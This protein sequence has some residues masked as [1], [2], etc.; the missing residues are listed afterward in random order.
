MPRDPILGRF[1]S[2]KGSYF[3]LEQLKRERSYKQAREIIQSDSLYKIGTQVAANMIIREWRHLRPIPSYRASRDWIQELGWLAQGLLV[4]AEHVRFFV[5]ESRRFESH[6]LRGEYEAAAKNLIEIEARVGI[7][8]WLAERQLMVRQMQEGFDAHKA[9]LAEI[10]AD[11]VDPLVGYLLAMISNRL[12][13]HVIPATFSRDMDQAVG[14]LR[15]LGK[16]HAARLVEFQCDPWHSE[17][18]SQPHPMLHACCD[19][20]LADR[21]SGALRILAY[22]SPEALTESQAK[23]LRAILNDLNAV[24]DDPALRR[25]YAWLIP[26][27]SLGAADACQTNFLRALDDFWC[28]NF[29]SAA[30]ECERLVATEPGAF[31]YYSL[32]AKTLA[33]QPIQSESPIDP[34]SISARLSRALQGIDAAQVEIDVFIIEIEAIALKLGATP[35]GIETW[36]WS[37]RLNNREA[38]IA[39]L[40]YSTLLTGCDPESY[41]SPDR[42]F[43][44][45]LF[46]IDTLEGEH[47]SIWLI[48]TRAAA[49]GG[50]L[51]L[52][53]QILPAFQHLVQA[54]HH[55]FTGA[56]QNALDEL[57]PLI[58]SLSDS[59]TLTNY[60]APEIAQ[61][62]YRALEG[63]CRFLD[64]ARTVVE[65]YVRN[66]NA[67]RYIP[68]VNLLSEKCG[69][70]GTAYYPVLVFLKNGDEQ[71]IYEAVD[72]YFLASNISGPA[73]FLNKVGNPLAAVERVLLRDVLVS[74]VLIRGPF[75]AESPDEQ[76]SL[77]EQILRRLFELCVDDQALVVNELAELEQNRVLA[78]AYRNVE[79]PK[80]SS[81]FGDLNRYLSSLLEGAFERYSAYR[82]FEGKGGQ[83][84]PEEQLLEQVAAGGQ[85]MSERRAESSDVLLSNIVFT[86]IAEY[87][88]GARMGV[89]ATLSTRIRHGSLENQLMRILDAN[90]LLARRDLK[91][92]YTCSKQVL[93]VLDTCPIEKQEKVANAYINF[94]GKIGQIYTDLMSVLRIRAQTSI[95][96]LLGDGAVKELAADDGLLDMRPAFSEEAIAKVRLASPRTPSAL[97]AESHRVFEEHFGNALSAV[98]NHL[99]SNVERQMHVELEVLDGIIVQ[100]LA[101]GWERAQ[102]R[103]WVRNAKDGIP[104]EIQIIQNWFVFTS[105]ADFGLNS[106]HRLFQVAARVVNFASNGRL[107]EIDFERIYDEAIGQDKGVILY[108]VLSILFRNIVQHSNLNP[109]HAQ[110]VECTFGNEHGR[111]TMTV[112]NQM[113]S[114]AGCQS[115]VEAARARLDAP[116][117]PRVLERS[118]GGTGL[119][120]VKALLRQ[121]APEIDVKVEPSVGAEPR[122]FCVKIIF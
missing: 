111:R 6:Y 119:C 110:L 102:L 68:F 85:R 95:L 38:D 80:F 44:R 121:I 14:R 36:Q 92:N 47:P 35:L 73:A 55:C 9:R 60:L 27:A 8:F 103:Q 29:G 64:A 43:V 86:I 12:E 15:T 42:R 30:R 113:Q 37:Q 91:G 53:P 66:K 97:I 13:P 32:L 19:R 3:A 100:E 118:P 41:L 50:E 76:R 105:R 22:A 24:I 81:D 74:P 98:R 106:M 84:A 112:C 48:K 56:F 114:I 72:D 89:N 104:N 61:W 101:D 54:E 46:E 71:D 88:W 65:Y 21:Y 59:S 40:R 4:N 31:H 75:W 26:G 62:E 49:S 115:A 33:C 67:L 69:L 23:Q 58:E 63:S 79:G 11:I 96:S 90:F 57:S 108:E 109:E 39:A 10:H 17:W 34:Q 117:D 94:T 87:I 107:G 99:K 52:P 25:L 18:K 51:Q 93:N 82:S 83:V 20:P 78:D 122:Q 5:S 1:A 16:L 28:G 45:E 70:R 2:R 77:R 120:R 7:S 116:G